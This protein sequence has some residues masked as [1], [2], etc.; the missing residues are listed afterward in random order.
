MI[1]EKNFLDL[2]V[3]SNMGTY[4]NIS[5]I[6]ISYTIGSLLDYNYFKNITISFDGDPKTIQQ[7]NFTENLDRPASAT[8][9][10][11]I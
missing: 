11:I 6:A 7:F 8:M 5:K 4:E 9:L 10:F 2:P 1:D 3:K